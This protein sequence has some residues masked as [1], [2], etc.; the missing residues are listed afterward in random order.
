MKPALVL[1]FVAFSTTPL[2]ST[3][4]QVRSTP[5]AASGPM[6][7]VIASAPTS[8]SV[9]SGG[10]SSRLIPI[11]PPSSDATRLAAIKRAT[12]SILEGQ[13]DAKSAAKNAG[14]WTA[15]IGLAGVLIG[16]LITF[17]IQVRVLRQ[18][19]DLANASS[20][21]EIG[22]SLVEWQLEQLSHLYGP[23]HA[24][25]LQSSALYRQMNIVLVAKAPDK[26]RLR[27]EPGTDFDGRIFEVFIGGAWVPFR[28]VTHIDQAYGFAYGIEEY[29]DEVVEIGRRM[30]KV[31]QE[32]AGYARPEDK[33]LSS[34]FGKYLG[35]FAV[36]SRM[37]AARKVKWA[38]FQAGN[39]EYPKQWSMAVDPSAAFPKPI[40]KMVEAGFNAIASALKAWQLKAQ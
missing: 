16:G 6:G 38:D 30:E 14:F 31:I 23:L 20:K 26:F 8:L 40:H 15:L 7:M 1:V 11:P 3:A 24:L 34:V 12:V 28:T 17:A 29:F 27:D 35:H 5:S 32:N 22:K 33:E 18:G 19:R 25:L 4:Q 10:A 13:Q 37:H 21:L 9:A 2:V 36:L 39:G